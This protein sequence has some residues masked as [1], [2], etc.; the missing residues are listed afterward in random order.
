V[1]RFVDMR[2]ARAK[3]CIRIGIKLR[4]EV[5]GG[6][7]DGAGRRITAID[8]WGQRR[9]ILIDIRMLPS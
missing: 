8:G 3:I 6:V 7:I 1:E 4:G 2:A 9:I 5:F